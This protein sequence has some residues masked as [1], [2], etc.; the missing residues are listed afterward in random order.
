LAISASAIFLASPQRLQVLHEAK[1]AKRNNERAY[2]GRKPS[3]TRE[4]FE[5]VRSI[6]GQPAA[7]I[8]RIAKEMGLTRRTLYRIKD[9]PAGAEAALADWDCEV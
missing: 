4:H 6:L 7:G 9:D 3:F 8:A 5:K 1:H 2:L